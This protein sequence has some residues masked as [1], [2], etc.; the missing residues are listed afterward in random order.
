MISFE[1]M[2]VSTRLVVAGIAVFFGLALIAGYTLVQISSDA[3]AAHNTRIKDLVEVSK[4]IISDFQKLEAEKKLTC[5][6]RRRFVWNPTGRRN[7]PH[8]I[9]VYKRQAP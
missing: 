3:L 5:G 2:R 9:D 4:G 8:R 6:R 1:R 7:S